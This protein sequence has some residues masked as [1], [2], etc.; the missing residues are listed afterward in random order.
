MGEQGALELRGSAQVC[1]DRTGAGECVL[2]TTDRGILRVCRGMSDGRQQGQTILV[3]GIQRS[4]NHYGRERGELGKTWYPWDE[5][6]GRD[7]LLSR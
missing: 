6:M 2:I 3:A 5:R 7:T 4:G 1:G